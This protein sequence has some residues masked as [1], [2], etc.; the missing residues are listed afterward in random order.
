MGAEGGREGGIVCFNPDA[1]HE[2]TMHLRAVCFLHPT[3][4]ERKKRAED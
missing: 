3:G 4:K 2:P 1:L